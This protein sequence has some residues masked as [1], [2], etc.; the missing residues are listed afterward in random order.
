[1]LNKNV[2]FRF[3]LS[4]L[5]IVLLVWAIWAL[6]QPPVAWRIA[7]I[8]LLRWTLPAAVGMSLLLAVAW[9]LLAVLRL[10]PAL[11]PAL[12]G[13]IAGLA[14]ATIQHVAGVIVP[15]SITEVVM[16]AMGAAWLAW[17]DT[18]RNPDSLG[19]KTSHL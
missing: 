16:T 3:A 11:F 8:A 15:I 7:N 9:A 18:W 2:I 10:S 13:A 4:S 12:S 14:V 1:M 6:S 19:T 17:P 5:I